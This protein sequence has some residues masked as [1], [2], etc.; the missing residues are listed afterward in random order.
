MRVRAC[1]GM[2][3]RSSPST[4]GAALP[5]LSAHRTRLRPQPRGRACTFPGHLGGEVLTLLLILRAGVGRGC[6]GTVNLGAL[7]CSVAGFR[8][9]P[10][11]LILICSYLGGCRPV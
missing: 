1:C 6:V 8:V 4:A 3:G 10:R 11:L 5:P 7:G 2:P 9:P